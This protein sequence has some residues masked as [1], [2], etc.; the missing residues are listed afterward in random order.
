[1]LA[2]CAVIDRMP[3]LFLCLCPRMVDVSFGRYFDIK[4]V[5]NQGNG[6]KLL[7]EMALIHV[8][9]TG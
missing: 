8:L 2:A 9:F 4:Y 5:I 7:L 6:T 3:C 1:M